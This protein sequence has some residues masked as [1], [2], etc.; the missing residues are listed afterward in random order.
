[1]CTSRA[2]FGAGSGNLAA[3]QRRRGGG[4]GR[5]GGWLFRGVCRKSASERISFDGGRAFAAALGTGR[6]IP[7]S[8]RPGLD[9]VA[10]RVNRYRLEVVGERVPVGDARLGGG[11]GR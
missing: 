10:R 1:M 7:A 4:E 11:S 5:R 6:Y 9:L 3:R 8:Q 2:Q